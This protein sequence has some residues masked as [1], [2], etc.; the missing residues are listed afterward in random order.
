M[1]FVAWVFV[2]TLVL[3][4]C[5]PVRDSKPDCDDDELLCP[6]S[7]KTATRVACNCECQLP[8]VPLLSGVKDNRYR[9]KLIACL[10]TSLNPSTA[11]PA[12][13]QA[14]NEMPQGQYNQ[15]VFK[16][17][18]EDIAEWLSL[19][20]KSQLAR[21]EQV[22]AGLA[23]QPHECTCGTEGATVTYAPCGESCDEK[24]CD[25]SN[26]QPIL[27]KGGILDV[28]SCYCTRTKACG[29]TSPPS[30]KPGLCRPVVGVLDPS[31]LE[32]RSASRLSFNGDV[33]QSTDMSE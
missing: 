13:R 32:D 16:F 7:K 10:P 33:Q 28:S 23:C 5:A 22:P 30:S 27:R 24:E 3:W 9:G 15:R 14:L 1:R 12:E 31:I 2:L 20:V 29:F 11:N 4:A 6:T 17:C 26:C 19:T 25:R 8:R 21:F 18:S